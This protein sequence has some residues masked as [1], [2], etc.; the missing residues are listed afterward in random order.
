MRSKFIISS[1]VAFIAAVGLMAA[2]ALA[3]EVTGRVNTSFGMLSSDDG[4]DSTS[5]LE[6]PGEIRIQGKATDGDLTGQWMLRLR[7]NNLTG[8]NTT[9]Y[10]VSWKAS[11]TVAVTVAPSHFGFAGAG[12]NAN[13]DYFRATVGANAADGA[14]PQYSVPVFKVDAALGGLNVGAG[15]ITTCGTAGKGWGKG[16]CQGD[17]LDDDDQTMALYVS[18][19]AGSI[20]YNAA[21]ATASG[22]AQGEVDED[23]GVAAY[24]DESASGSALQ[25]GLTFDLGGMKLG[26]DYASQTAAGI[27]DGED[28]TSSFLGL[29]FFMGSSLGVDFHSMS[30]DFGGDD[31]AT[32]T[33]IDAHYKIKAGEKSYYGVEFRNS[34]TNA[35]TAVGGTAP[36]D[37]TAQYIGFGLRVNY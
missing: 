26:A 21:F 15:I 28:I 7:N 34:T 31:P 5:S 24:T 10:Q 25:A 20:S 22:T 18:G 23:T 12:V 32:A 13:A 33:E 14:F 4:T 1:L 19:S 2:P 36:D 35:G 8:F 37:N 6:A 29:A 11:D 30:T 16:L 9:R 3:I 17:S 27:A